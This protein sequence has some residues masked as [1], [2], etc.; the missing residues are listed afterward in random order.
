M[1]FAT[2]V[3]DKT[4]DR[5]SFSCGKELLDNYF[6]NQASQ[7][8]KKKLTVCFVL[9]DNYNTK[10]QGYYT[11]SSN[12]VASDLIP[13]D[14]KKRLPKSY[15]S[16]PAILIGRL[17]VDKISQK[18]GLGKILL[19]DALKRSYLTSVTIGAFAVIVDPIDY[20]AENYYRTFGFI[21]LPGSG[22]MFLPILTIRELL[23]KSEIID[24]NLI[25][26]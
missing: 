7:D 6:K 5:S 26:K 4:H 12:S 18:K 15:T 21:K 2:V 9:P 23:I 8:V 19:V 10:V 3:L 25:Q 11:L 24:N 16:I 17:A 1:R 20:D 22:K 13:L 14:L